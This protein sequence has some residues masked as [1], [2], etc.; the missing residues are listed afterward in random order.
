MKILYALDKSPLSR[1]ADVEQ[2]INTAAA[3]AKRGAEVQLA[4]PWSNREVPLTAL[5]LSD[6]YGLDFLPALLP[7]LVKPRSEIHQQLAFDFWLSRFLKRHKFDCLYTRKA[8]IAALALWCGAKVALDQYKPFSY[9]PKVVQ[10]LLNYVLK[11]PNFQALFLHSQLAWEDYKALARPMGKIHVAR[12]GL[13]LDPARDDLTRAALDLSEK[14]LAVYAGRIRSGKGLHA[15]LKL[16]DQHKTV[17]FLFI[18]A[19]GVDRDMEVSIQ[20]R[21]NARLVHWVKAARLRNYLALSDILLLPPVD[22]PLKVA[23]NTVL[24]LKTYAYLSAERAIFGPASA[25]V[26]EILSNGKDACLVPPGDDL[27]IARAFAQLVESEALRERL[28]H[29]AKHRAQE[30]CWEKRADLILTQLRNC[31]SIAEFPQAVQRKQPA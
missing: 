14:L 25:D 1:D 2:A 8:E 22:E 30:L 18:G 7:C 16:A 23:K 11:H 13:H 26:C 24:P 4:F 28:A 21:P 9:H 29:G 19:D 12:N 15:L 20:K 5:Q 10:K 31:L 6:T 17:Q 27:M 3:L